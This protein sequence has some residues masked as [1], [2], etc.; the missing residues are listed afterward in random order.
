[1]DPT[2]AE[3][4]AGGEGA[5]GVTHDS[6]T[7]T[8]TLDADFATTLRSMREHRGWNRRELATELAYDRTYVSHVEGGTRR[9]S[10]TFAERADAVLG[11]G[12]ELLA[13]WE[14][15]RRGDGAG[16]LLTSA[17]RL[18]LLDSHA[19]VQA[20]L[21][22]IV[23]EA[24]RILVCAGSRS[25]D[26]SYL[27]LIEDRLA[28]DPGLAYYR[29]LFGPPWHTEL[30]DHLLRVLAIR[31]PAATAQGAGKSVFLGLFDDDDVEPER[32]ICANEHRALL[33]Q[34]SL[35]GLSW[36]DTALVVNDPLA[37]SKWA[38]RMQEA[39]R[40][41]RAIETEHGILDLSVLKE[42]DRD[43]PVPA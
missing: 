13:K 3:A 2:K 35:N 24:S 27:R 7:R 42:R 15:H 37:A 33:P 40:A 10:R 29:I 9:P 6:R 17:P 4:G 16:G 22:S 20:A 11:A 19:D 28:A 12:G 21:W 34:L 23:D 18:Q 36:Y 31:D 25:R 38:A 30:R 43:R 5:H 8:G 41:G 32:F 26:A 1:M 14:R 39:Y